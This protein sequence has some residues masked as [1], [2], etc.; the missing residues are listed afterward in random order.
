MQLPASV[1]A[2]LCRLELVTCWT[3]QAGTCH[4]LG[5]LLVLGTGQIEGYRPLRRH[6]LL[7]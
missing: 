7:T 6:P 5:H 4:P 2:G 1:S 3:V